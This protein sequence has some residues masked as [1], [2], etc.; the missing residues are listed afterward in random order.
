MAIISVNQ[1]RSFEYSESKGSKGSV[2][3]KGSVEFLARFDGEVDFNVLVEDQTV[4][5]GLGNRP[6]PLLNSLE[7]IGGIPFYVTSRKFAYFKGDEQERAAK[8]TIEYD[9]KREDPQDPDEEKPGQDANAETWKKITVTTEQQQ[10]PLTNQGDDG[11]MGGGPAFGGPGLPPRN[12]AGDPMDGLTETRCLVKL[13]YTNSQVRDP[14]F[15]W[16]LSFTNKTNLQE[17][18]GCTRRTLLCQ[19]FNA[20][21]DDKRQLWTISVE[22]L[23]DPKQH[24]VVYYDM[25][26]N[27]KVDGERRAIVD[28]VGNPVSK[29]VPLDGFGK[30]V[31]I[32]DATAYGPG[33][34]NPFIVELTAYPYKE[35]EMADIFEFGGI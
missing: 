25:G 1:L 32:A 9:N 11:M 4:W 6:I 3:M 7:S 17:F 34:R 22:W 5:A 12:T 16:L 28:V 29:P 23:Y 24:V 14:N 33:V 10:V 30:A 20:D 15:A 19:G 2:D 13:T 31:R 8:I 35:V 18:L 21:Y 26:L 27:E